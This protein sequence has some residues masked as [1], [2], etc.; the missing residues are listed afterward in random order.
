MLTRKIYFIR[1]GETILNAKKIRQGE[2]GGLSEKGHLQAF[3]TGQRLSYFNIKNIFCSPFQRAIETSEEVLKS[4]NVSIEYTPLLSERKN[5]S[6]IIGL[7]YEDPITFEAINF[8]DKSFHSADARWDDEENFQDLKDRALKLKTF[9]EKNSKSS[10]LC[11][12][13]GIFLKMFLCVLLYGDKL[14]VSTYIKM[15]TLNPADNAGITVLEYSPLNF[16]SEPW[17]IIAY[18]DS[19]INM[20]SLRI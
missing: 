8:M 13:H 2:D 1:H 16:F 7:Q 14:D 20:R 9:L 15:S 18:N 11:I 12:T 3:Q 10:T 6:K 19:P 17:E 4:L 5:P